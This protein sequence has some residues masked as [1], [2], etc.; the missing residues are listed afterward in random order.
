[1]KKLYLC[2]ALLLSLAML[3]SCGGDGNA[4]QSPSTDPTIEATAT[5]DPTDPPVAKPT[6]PGGYHDHNNRAT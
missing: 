1:M 2:L 5:P 4:T 3:A 6:P